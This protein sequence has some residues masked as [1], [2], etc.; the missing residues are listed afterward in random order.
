M[1]FEKLSE[2]IYTDFGIMNQKKREEKTLN[3]EYWLEYW[4][5]NPCLEAPT[6]ENIE[7]LRNK[8]FVTPLVDY[9]ML[10]CTSL[11][12]LI[13]HDYEN[14][15]STENLHQFHLI[16]KAELKR[17][18]IPVLD[19][20]SFLIDVNNKKQGKIITE[21]KVRREGVCPECNSKEHVISYG[22]KWKCKLHNKYW[23]KA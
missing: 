9:E 14:L 15:T 11:K 18:G 4:L 2:L 12:E 21:E 1:F 19:R 22:D 5:K 3:S 20:D 17:R 8:Q 16:L 23:R 6:P 13:A 7:Y 10:L